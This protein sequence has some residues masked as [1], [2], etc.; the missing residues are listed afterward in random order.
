MKLLEVPAALRR[1]TKYDLFK[2]ELD[3][4]RGQQFI[5]ENA[6]VFFR[7]QAND[8]VGPVIIEES[9]NFADLYY[10]ME[11]GKVGVLTPVPENVRSEILFNLI[12]REAELADILY[13]HHTL[14]QNRMFYTYKKDKVLLGP[15]YITEYT[16]IIELE[17]MVRHGEVFVPNEK[18]HFEHRE[19]KKIA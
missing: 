9:Q 4:L 12:L 8:I 13:L 16:K 2:G 17:D 1:A 11:I 18:Q 19:Y 10:M 7:N 6:T 15:F 5:K 3:N 14:K